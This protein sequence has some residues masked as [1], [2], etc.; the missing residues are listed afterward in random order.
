MIDSGKNTAVKTARQHRP[1]S[2]TARV[3]VFVA[4]AIGLSLVLISHLVLSAVHR[5]FAE[6]DAE[7]LQ[8]MTTAIERV[9]GES[10]GQ[11]TDLVEALSHAISGHHGVYFEVQNQRGE[12][13]YSTFKDRLSEKAV[14]DAPTSTIHAANLLSWQADDTTYN[15]A[16]SLIRVDGQNF[17]VATAIDMDFHLQFLSNFSQSLWLIMMLAGT[18]TLF[19]AWLGVRQGHTPI[20]ELSES[21]RTVQ[22][23]R[24]SV[25]LD[26]SNVPRELQGLVASFN[27]MIGRLENSFTRLI[28]FSADIAHELR[29]PLT[30]IITQTQVGLSKARSEGEYRELLYSN[31]EEQER[32]AKMVNDMLWLAKTD[33]DLLKPESEWLD[34]ASEVRAILEFFEALAEEKHIQLRLEGNAPKVLGDR[35]MLRRAVSNLLSNAIRYTQPGEQVKVQLA[36]AANDEVTLTVQNPGPEIPPE[37]LTKLFDR[38]YRVDPARARQSDGAGLGLAIVKSIIDAHGGRVQVSS[39]QEITQFTLFFPLQRNQ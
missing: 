21:L 14:V 2:L 38:F 17:R 30:N 29:T 37:Q 31:L 32:L 7:E 28:H 6:Q 13:L 9:L 16:I 26:Q 24:L 34:L 33:H 10:L 22:A 27:L 4:L 36:T 8:V 39:D 3:T 20:R 5:H 15:G 11:S 12:I 1:L 19:A 18:V 25:R 35:S 23:D